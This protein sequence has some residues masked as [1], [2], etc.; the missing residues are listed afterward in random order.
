M[1]LLGDAVVALNPASGRT[2]PIAAVPYPAGLAATRGNVVVGS[3]A[4]GGTWLDARGGAHPIAAPE[5][6]VRD[7]LDRGRRGCRW[8]VRVAHRLREP[9]ALTASAWAPRAAPVGSAS[10]TA[11]PPLRYVAGDVPLLSVANSLD[12][13]VTIVNALKGETVRRIATGVD[14]VA[15]AVDTDRVGWIANRG[16]GS[17]TRFDLAHSGTT[18]RINVGAE[19]SAVLVAGRFVWVA[20]SGDG[21]VSR[22]D[23]SDWSGPP[24]RIDVGGRPDS[25]AFGAGSVWVAGA[26]DHVIVRLDVSTGDV[27]DRIPVGFEVTGLA[28]ANGRLMIGA[29]AGGDR[30]RGGTLRIASA[31]P[32][33]ALDPALADDAASRQLLAMTNDGLVAFRRAPGAQGSVVVPDIA[34]SLPAPSDDGQTYTF[35]VRDGVEYSNGRKV[36]ALDFRTAI[37][38]TLRHGGPAAALYRGIEGA[39]ACTPAACNLFTG[40]RVDDA[41]ATVTFK[42]TAPDPAFLYK[43]ALPEAAA[44]H[45]VDAAAPVPATGPYE[46]AEATDDGI[47]LERNEHFHVWSDEAQPDGYPDRITWRLALGARPSPPSNSSRRTSCTSACRPPSS[48]WNDLASI[49]P[50]RL[51]VYPSNQVWYL[52]MNRA[53]P[54]F[55]VRDGDEEHGNRQAVNYA[56]ARHHIATLLGGR[57][58][59]SPTC[60]ALPPGF[61]AYRGFC[62]SDG[63]R[64]SWVNKNLRAARNEQKYHGVP[65]GLQPF[66]LATFRAGHRV[67]KYVVRRLHPILLSPFIVEIPGD[68]GQ[69]RWAPD[70]YAAGLAVASPR[71]PDP[72][73]ILARLLSC[74]SATGVAGATENLA[75]FCDEALSQRMA[76]AAQAE[77]T[78]P[79]AGLRR[80]SQIDRDVDS[81]APWAPLASTNWIDFVSS[82]VGNYQY[83]VQT[84]SLLDQMW[85][86]G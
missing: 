22:I 83:N 47:V 54:R 14:P 68:Y 81:V 27:Q 9:L 84:G 71:Y 12:D 82:R 63:P 55:M 32:S 25:L 20:D 26:S 77:A 56:I 10:E 69:L 37:E 49:S 43:L 65:D 78:D 51:H 72:S 39:A 59:A 45:D 24:Q 35:H 33:P 13:T 21:T 67:A 42:L 34:T 52:F 1:G 11:R 79:A 75:R 85:V 66:A 4:G 86:R 28:F 58:A 50:D 62:P 64:E 5:C 7:R 2:T 61:P 38:R 8:R 15:V 41:G 30:H 31:E 46:I 53:F 74:D 60:Q 48:C 76:A 29:R 3:V 57:L 44:V 73:A 23:H 40:I 70:P 16:S 6:G 36:T 18:E 17:V 80:W 19:P